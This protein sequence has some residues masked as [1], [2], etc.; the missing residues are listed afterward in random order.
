MQR[1]MTDAAPVRNDPSRPRAVHRSASARA[2]TSRSAR[3]TGSARASPTPAPSTTPM[4]K[5]G[6]DIL[7]IDVPF[8]F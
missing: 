5:K 7:Q 3:S 1:W 8:A 6:Y 2:S 4:A